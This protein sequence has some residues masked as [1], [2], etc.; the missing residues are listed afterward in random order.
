MSLKIIIEDNIYSVDIPEDVT[1]NGETFFS[2]LDSD[3]DKGWQMSRQWVDK[4]DSLQRCQIVADRLAD[5]I[6]NENEMLTYLLA[7]YIV[8]RL[9][10]V[11]EVHI[12]TEGEISETRFKSGQ[13]Q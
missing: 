12:D 10:G 9:P 8:S 11:Q 3:M 6:S 2:K 1:Q 4:P 13:A 5:A 7:G